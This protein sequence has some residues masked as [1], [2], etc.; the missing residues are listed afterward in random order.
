MRRFD[1]IITTA[2]IALG[3]VGMAGPADAHGHHHRGYDFNHA[4]NHAI[5]SRL[6][7]NPGMS[8]A[9]APLSPDPGG[10][11]VRMSHGYP[12][13]DPRCTPGAIN[14]TVTP[15]VLDAP[16]FRTRCIRNRVTTEREKA[17]TYRWYDIRHPRHNRGRRQ[18]CELDHLVPLELGGAD[19][20]DNIWPECGPAHGPFW[21]RDFKRKDL[22][23][24]YLAKK[25]KE[26]KMPLWQAQQDIARDWTTYLAKAIHDCPFGQCR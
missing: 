25:V 26:G 8:Q 24:N 4:H 1:R 17:V 13:P 6:D 19:T 12:I 23:E 3:F 11:H 15:D 18:I 7:V 2:L 20:L 22:V 21:K 5:C 9:L 10:C 14:P 16:G